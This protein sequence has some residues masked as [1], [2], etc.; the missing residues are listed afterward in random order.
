MTGIYKH[1]DANGKTSYSDQLP[2]TAGQ[3]EVIAPGVPRAA[4]KSDEEARREHQEV[5]QY[6]KE[7]QK[8]VPKLHDYWRYIEFLRSHS[9]SRHRLM[10]EALQRQDPE[11]YLKLQKYPAFRPLRDTAPRSRRQQPVPA[12]PNVVPDEP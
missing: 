7:T 10:L 3:L 5:V 4:K 1:V 9:P 11:A 6:I 2:S 8:R 12:P